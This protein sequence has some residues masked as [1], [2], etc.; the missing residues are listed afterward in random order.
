MDKY[1]AIYEGLFLRYILVVFFL[2]ALGSKNMSGKLL[3][4]CVSNICSA[5]GAL[6]VVSTKQS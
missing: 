3:C 5:H 1:R 6:S 4:L 2:L